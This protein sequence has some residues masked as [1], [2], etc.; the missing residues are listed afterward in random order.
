MPGAPVV[1][2]DWDNALRAT[3]YRVLI[4]RN[5]V[6]TPELKNII[7]TESEV[8]VSD[9]DSATPITVTVSSRNSKGGESSPT[10]PVNATVVRRI[11]VRRFNN[12]PG[13]LPVENK[14]KTPRK[15]SH[16]HPKPNQRYHRQL[17]C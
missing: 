3:S 10:D 6:N 13:R 17:R 4:K 1:F 2:I 9:I 14:T 5:V 7:V 8:T 11:L 12:F 15:P 16:G